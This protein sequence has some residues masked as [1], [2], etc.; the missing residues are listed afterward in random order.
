MCSKWA[1]H[2][3]SLYLETAFNISMDSGVASPYC[4]PDRWFHQITR[5]GGSFSRHSADVL[6][7]SKRNH[8]WSVAC[9]LAKSDEDNSY[10]M[11]KSGCKIDDDPVFQRRVPPLLLPDNGAV[12]TGS[13]RP[14]ELGA[15]EGLARNHC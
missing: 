12:R 13:T 5:G 15:G 4:I 10:V 3:P 6:I 7:I 9:T 2:C 11:G 1:Q 14:L 8:Q